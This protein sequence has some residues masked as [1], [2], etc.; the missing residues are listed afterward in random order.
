MKSLADDIK[1]HIKRSKR[2]NKP[3]K[4]YWHKRELQKG[5]QKWISSYEYDLFVTLTFREETEHWLAKKR[6]EKW[7]ASLNKE[8][9]GR[10]YKQRGRG[11]RGVVVYESQK[12]GALHMHVL[13]GADGLKELNME[14]MAKLWKCNGQKNKNTGA[15]LNRI[16]NGH[17]DI[18]VYDPEQGAIQYMTKH[19]YKGS[20]FEIFVPRKEREDKAC[21]IETHT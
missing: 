17:A 15:L 16:V 11:I 21:S 9:F 10:R 20:E 2:G 12:R 18:K 4:F 3:Q 7:I 5:W 13:L 14:Y 6:F 8:L 1:A 19:V